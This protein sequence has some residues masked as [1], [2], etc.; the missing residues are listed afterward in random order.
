VKIMADDKTDVAL[1]TEQPLDESPVAEPQV[2]LGK[3]KTVDKLKEA[4]DNLEK[5]ALKD[6]QKMIQLEKMVSAVTEVPIAQGQVDRQAKSQEFFQRFAEDPESVLGEVVQRYVSPFQQETRNNLYLA[7]LNRLNQAYG[8]VEQ[9][10]PV[11]QE[12]VADLG[13]VPSPKNL[14]RI[15]NLAKEEINKAS[16]NVARQ[17]K[18]VLASE[19]AKEKTGAVVETGTAASGEE[20]GTTPEQ[21]IDKEIEEA[22][23]E[24]AEG[25]Y[26]SGRVGARGDKVA[27]LELKKSGVVFPT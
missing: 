23:R 17:N 10:A 15:Y 6:H 5:M 8:D 19:I 12:I 1:E 25:K 14:E 21:R 18:Q 27:A 3:F 20:K 11:M 7:E 16:G 22:K 13:I 4:Y 2:D 26:K 9:V 24:A